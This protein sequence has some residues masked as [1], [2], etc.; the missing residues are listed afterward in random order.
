[1]ILVSSQRLFRQCLGARLEASQR[2]VVVREAESVEEALNSAPV[3]EAHVVLV[4]AVDLDAGGFRLLAG[5][6]TEKGDPRAVVLGLSDAV[7]QVRRCAEAG[8]SGFAYRD[9]SLEDLTRTLEAVSRGEQVCA[10]RVSRELFRRLSRLGRSGRRQVQM[11][12]LC[13][14]PRQMEVLRWTARGLGNQE[15]GERLKLSPYTVKNHMH[16]I[17]E[18]LG[19][20]DRTEAVAYAFRNRWLP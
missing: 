8:I 1:L 9:T 20:R 15:I 16:K 7:A 18:R 13:L 5:L 14:T 4:D 6:D 3:E 11:E 17:L 10:S 19:V 2:F 12:A